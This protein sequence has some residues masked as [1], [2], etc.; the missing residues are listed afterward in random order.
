M[1][2]KKVKD[3]YRHKDRVKVIRSIFEGIFLL[4]LLVVT[5]RA[6]VRFKKYEPF[7]EENTVMDETGFIALS[8]FGVDR[9]GTNTLISTEQFNKHLEALKM[10]GYVTITQNDIKNYYENGK[11]LP[12]KAL[13]LMV[14]DGRNETAIFAQDIME[15]L[16]YKAT[17]FS[18]AK[19]LNSKDNRFLKAKDLKRIHD[20]GWWE[21]GTNGYRLSF[22][23]VFDRYDHY[24]GDL[25][26]LEFSRNAKY[27]KKDY[28]HYLM[29]YKRDAYDIP[30]ETYS[31]LRERIMLDY[32]RIE[33]IYTNDVGIMPMA[34][35][36]MHS[37]TGA[38]G[39]NQ[40]A[41]DI[42]EEHI[43]SLFTMNFNR[44]GHCFNNQE[45]SIYDLT[46]VQPQAYWSANHL[47]MRVK[48]DTKEDITFVKGTSKNANHWDQIAGA[49]EFENEIIILTSEPSSEG[50]I[51][52]NQGKSYQ[53]V[54]LSVQL[55]GN[56]LGIQGIYLR[57]NDDLSQYVKVELNHNIL[58]VYEKNNEVE[59]KIYELNL[60]E[61]DGIKYL[62]VEEDERQCLIG[63]NKTVLKY[64]DS[65]S[66]RK[67]A[68]ANIADLKKQ[69]KKTNGESEYYIPEVGI[70]EQG[71]R[72]LC[73]ELKNNQLS[74]RLDGK[75]VI[76]DLVIN[77]MAKGNIQLQ[78]ACGEYQNGYSQRSLVDNVYDGIFEKLQIYNITDE[79]TTLVYSDLLEGWDKISYQANQRWNRILNWFIKHL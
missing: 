30:T 68:K 25:S 22:I 65:S 37:N 75:Q 67:Q 53:D 3:P 52:L 48:Q 8:Y 58:Y 69:N 49:A 23:N 74:I 29:D 1:A 15:D 73:L 20:T 27:L 41:S 39:T 50:R 45:N 51:C 13:F 66:E 35:C 47:L 32:H 62:T 12:K 5:I 71:N 57:A 14:E 18:Y 70:S 46:R 6:L 64:S 33:E 17:M 42:N 77:C 54:K 19:N 34:H 44:E 40:N 59:N 10:N 63:E 16:N 72:T 28:N 2:I 31:E 78:S 61:F 4:I 24:L 9:T 38:F 36:L 7:S 21:I 55:T 76:K 11:K 26:S 60:D 56:K 79:T 43:R